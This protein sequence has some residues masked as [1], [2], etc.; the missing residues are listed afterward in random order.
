MPQ[1]EREIVKARAARLRAHAEA[2]RMRWLDTLIGTTQRVLVESDR[3]HG[4]GTSNAP[5]RLTGAA[6]GTLH[7]AV[8]T[9]RD[10][11]QLIGMIA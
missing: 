10:G 8:V 7:D 9:A 6:K 5:V 1:V 3:G 4:H 11:N 2:R